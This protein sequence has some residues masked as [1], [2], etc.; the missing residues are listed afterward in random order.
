MTIQRAKCTT[1]FLLF[2]RHI[3]MLA[4]SRDQVTC[5]DES[6]TGQALI[7]PSQRKIS[8]LRRK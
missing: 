8:Q 3:W 1:K 5:K 4:P 2:E 6:K 7:L